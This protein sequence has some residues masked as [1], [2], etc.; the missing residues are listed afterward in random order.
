MFRY[1]NNKGFTLI[2]LLVVIAI[3]GILA[4]IVLVNLGNTRK[5]AKDASAIASMSSIRSAAEIYRSSSLSG[6]YSGMCYMFGGAGDVKRLR[7]AVTKAVGGDFTDP[8]SVAKIVVCNQLPGN[9][10]FTMYV[11]L[12]DGELFCIDSNGFANRVGSVFP[13]PGWVGG[14]K[15]K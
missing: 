15:C 2:E 14:E 1:A 10:T 4:S 7:A 5:S 8:N 12:N 6:T 9:K 13:W 11:K 3:I